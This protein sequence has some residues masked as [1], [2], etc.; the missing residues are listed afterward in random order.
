MPAVG[1]NTIFPKKVNTKFIVKNN[2]L[3]TSQEKTIKVFT[4]PIAPGEQL[5]LLTIP[6]VSEA[7]IQHSLL[8][9][10]LRI[11]TENGIIIVVD[12]NINLIQFGTEQFEFLSSIGI[13]S[14]IELPTS[15]VGISA[16]FTL[17]DLPSADGDGYRRL[18]PGAYAFVG[19]IVLPDEESILI[20]DDLSTGKSHIL[21]GYGGNISHLSSATLP[22][23]QGG[24]NSVIV[25]GLDISAGVGESAVVV[26]NSSMDRF[27]IMNCNIVGGDYNIEC[28]SGSHVEVKSTHCSAAVTS[29]IGVFGNHCIINDSFL[30]N[31]VQNIEFAADAQTSKLQVISSTLDD[32]TQNVLISNSGVMILSGSNI[33]NAADGLRS[34]GAIANVGV[35]ISMCSFSSLTDGVDM[36]SGLPGL[37]LNINN[38]HFVDT[39]DPFNGFSILTSNVIIRGNWDGG[40]LPETGILL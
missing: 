40:F 13:S 1:F 19:D 24:G 7:D 26:S 29:N 32:A 12:S 10:E 34:L 15:D 3:G 5:D 20:T 23:L 35:L 37:G 30:I 33:G 18:Q 22:V 4:R 17:A 21:F 2:T 28:A 36:N 6:F 27:V 8:K 39:T 16:I 11:K 38:C 14:G 31:S 25:F 9:G